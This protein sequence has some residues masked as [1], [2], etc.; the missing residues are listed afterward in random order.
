MMPSFANSAGWNWIGP[1]SIARNA[2][3]TCE[4][5]PGSLGITSSA[6][7]AAAIV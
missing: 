6:I 5:I 4:P 2:P 7:D 3:F 1:S